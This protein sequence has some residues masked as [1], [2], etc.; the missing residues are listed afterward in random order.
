MPETPDKQKRNALSITL[1]KRGLGQDRV[2]I[3][4]YVSDEPCG[5]ISLEND[6]ADEFSCMIQDYLD[7]VNETLK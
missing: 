2:H 5:Y 4:I 7:K 6:Q 1:D 3:T